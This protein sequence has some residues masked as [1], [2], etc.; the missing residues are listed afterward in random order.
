MSRYCV[1]GFH[2]SKVVK[3]KYANLCEID[4]TLQFESTNLDRVRNYRLRLEAL[5][6]AGSDPFAVSNLIAIYPIP[7]LDE[8]HNVLV[9]RCQ[10]CGTDISHDEYCHCYDAPVSV[11]PEIMQ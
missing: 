11:E 4:R 7:L 6:F 1:V 9:A 10:H 5:G 8:H 3:G 2:Y